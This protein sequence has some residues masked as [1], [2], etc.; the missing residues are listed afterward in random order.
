MSRGLVKNA[1]LREDHA[2]G[3]ITLTS[4]LAI[5][6]P[7]RVTTDWLAHW[8][9]KR[10]DTV[11]LAERSGPGWRTLT[12]A[13][14][15]QQVR[16]VAAALLDRGLT[17][18]TPILILS[19]NGIEHGVL[20]LAAQM[21]GIPVVPVA[22]QYSLIPGAQKQLSYIAELIRPGLVFAVDGKSF[23]AGLSVD[24]LSGVDVVVARNGTNRQ[25][26]FDDFLR[27]GVSDI[28][29][30]AS[31]VGPDT[32]VKILMTSGSTSNPK[33]VLTTH[34]MMCAN[35]AQ[36][37][38]VLPF[39]KDR[40]PRLVDWLPWNHVFGGSNNFN[41]VLS[42][43]G[44]LYIDGGKPVP[45]L[46]GLTIENNLLM[47]GT[48]AYNVP[49]GFALLRDEMRQ[50]RALRQRYFEDLDMLF[51]AG[52][53]LPRD[54]WDDLISM[55][56]DVRGDPPFV[57]T[58]W[59]MTETAPACVF[60]Q[61][62][63]PEPGLLGVPLPGV[64][65]KLVPE[66]DARYELRVKG[67]NVTPGYFDDSARTAD[68][69]DDEGFL[70]TGDAMTLADP[71]NASKGLRFDGRISE[72]F[73]LSTG[74]WVR[75]TDLRLNAIT[76]F[77]PL[78]QDVVLTG[79][80]RSEIGALIIP[81]A[82]LLA[83]SS[84]TDDGGAVLSAIAQADIAERLKRMSG[85]SAGSST[86]VVRAMILSEPPSMADGEITAKGNLNFRKLLSRRAGLVDRLYD[87]EDT[88]VIR[89]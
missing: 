7:V 85:T 56:T 49:A 12:Y 87:D 34:R 51:Y 41:Q 4:P 43:G 20:A 62:S 31:G 77:A 46:I 33:G 2:D 74:I 50:N 17:G 29:H 37:K 80:G 11:F 15:D 81:G 39:L 52:A 30:A 54:V 48:I 10:P 83:E 22:E 14:A 69:F 59:G 78:A 66:D 44:S 8:A 84:V 75:T 67:P 25:E 18:S 47:N 9:G 19:G 63:A 86:H 57:T 79:E 53:S 61:T 70:R 45:A 36:Y 24:A 28:D 76:A 82:A 73:K 40:P 35:Q 55:A 13:A 89:V 21:V 71:R 26:S 1:V 5:P 65:A 58:C 23:S 88:A 32:V 64:T 27:G 38:K 6:D 60:Q 3:S 42:N 72:D 16:A 68:T